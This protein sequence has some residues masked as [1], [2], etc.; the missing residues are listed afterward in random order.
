MTPGHFSTTAMATTTKLKPWVTNI[1]LTTLI[2]QQ[3]WKGGGD[4]VG[5]GREGNGQK[6]DSA[7]L[8]PPPTSSDLPR[9]FPQGLL[10][11]LPL[12]VIWYKI[13][14]GDNTNKQLFSANA[15]VSQQCPPKTKRFSTVRSSHPAPKNAKKVRVPHHGSLSLFL[16]PGL[17]VV[18]KIRWQNVDKYFRKTTTAKITTNTKTKTL[19]YFL[20]RTGL[21]EWLTRR[22]HG[23]AQNM[24]QR[25]KRAESFTD[26]NTYSY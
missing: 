9:R 6:K 7:F 14:S 5:K 3:T 8:P 23:L 10:F 1:V 20:K 25:S 2:W 11:L 24:G 22:L 18:A 12:I 4:G 15:G 26:G 13:K 19:P 21:P 17:K 16:C